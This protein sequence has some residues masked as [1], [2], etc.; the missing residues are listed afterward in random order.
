MFHSNNQ[1]LKGDMSM[2]F[3][4]VFFALIAILVVAVAAQAADQMLNATVSD[5][6]VTNDKNGNEYVRLII[7]EPRELDGVAYV[8]SVAVMCFRE[9]ANFAKTLK[10][11][12]KIRAIVSPNEYQG[13]TS[14]RLISWAN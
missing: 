14:Y 10:K 8:S 13:K 3:K 1:A 11:G 12:D 9:T 2:K 5:I 4:S 7:N 6:V